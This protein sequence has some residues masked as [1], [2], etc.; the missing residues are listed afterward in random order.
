MK[1]KRSLD[2]VFIVIGSFIASFSVACILLPNDAIDYGTAGI[3]I[4]LSKVFGWNLTWCVIG[5]VLPFLVA[6]R[7]FLGKKFCVKA[8]LGT[9]AYTVGLEIF[10]MVSLELNVEHFIAVAF[11]G[12]ILGVGLSFIIRHG[13][14]IDGSEILANIILEKINEVYN[15]SFSITG[16]LL[17]FNLCI[18]AVVLVVLDS[19]SALMSLLVYFVA[20]SVI[21]HFIDHFESIKKVTIIVKDSKE[22]VKTIKSDLKKTCTVTES[23]GAVAGSN[24]T[25][26]CYVNYFELQQLKDLIEEKQPGA[27]VTITTIDEIWK[28]QCRGGQY[29]FV[30]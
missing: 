20:T 6:S 16:I 26:I 8:C 29:S 21:D 5:V 7:V 30:G 24:E 28:S 3:A 27:F 19:N 15:R 4:I 12:V 11:G 2:Y 14:C 22:L 18:Y 9:V 17:C 10:K 25:I 1:Y 23:Y 13:G